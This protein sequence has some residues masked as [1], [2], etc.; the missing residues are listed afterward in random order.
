M[1]PGRSVS[2]LGMLCLLISLCCGSC[3]SFYTRMP[4][5]HHILPGVR[6]KTAD[7]RHEVIESLSV[8]EAATLAIQNNIELR[9]EADSLDLRKGALSL[10]IRSYLPSLE[11]GTSSDDRL[12]LY[13]PDSYSKVVSVSLSQ[14]LWDGGRLALSRALSLAELGLLYAEHERRVRAAGEEAVSAYRSVVAAR[15]RLDI[16]RRSLVSAE[17]ERTI[18]VAEIELGLAK[19]MDILIVDLR[20]SGM[21]LDVSVAELG[22]AQAEEVLSEA[23]GLSVLPALSDGLSPY[24]R[25]VSLEA[26]RIGDLA[27]E[28]S[29]LLEQSRQSILRRGAEARSAAFSWF[30]TIGLKAGAQV[31]GSQFPLHR[32]SWSI[33]INIDFASPYVSG[34][35]GL[36]RGTQPPF[37]STRTCHTRLLPYSDAGNALDLKAARLALKAEEDRY[38]ALACDVR[39]KA[40]AAVLAYTN[41]GIKRDIAIRSLRLS[42]SMALVVATQIEIGQAVRGAAIEAELS[43]AEKEIELVDAVTSLAAAEWDVESLLEIPPGSLAQ[44]VDSIPNAKGGPEGQ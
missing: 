40:I 29:F 25:P 37:D 31:A 13:T 32:A 26:Q 2:E 9:A 8:Q 16:K 7:V 22:L 21:E 39:R 19:A 33:G 36:Q 27:V 30:P 42:E 24:K 5:G 41:A 1:S 43:R 20:L 11:L 44:F 17:G 28:R 4:T 38:R 15:S 34:G 10:G 23:L 14:L 6:S 18:L 35:L 12:S 3:I